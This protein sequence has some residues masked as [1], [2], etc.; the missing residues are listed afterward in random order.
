MGQRQTG[1]AILS[2]KN[3]MVKLF[4]TNELDD[5]FFEQKKRNMYFSYRHI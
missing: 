4:D 3:T 2:I 5:N 1:F